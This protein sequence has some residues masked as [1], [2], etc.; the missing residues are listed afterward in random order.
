MNS[1]SSAESRCESAERRGERENYTSSLYVCATT[2]A[3]VM[4]GKKFCQ[5]V[6]WQ[7]VKNCIDTSIRYFRHARAKYCPRKRKGVDLA[8][9]KTFYLQAL[10]QN[11]PIVSCRRPP[12]RQGQ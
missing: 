5:I 2:E 10:R 1:E 7:Y 9:L 4:P 6:C 8:L 11:H 3:R 12:P